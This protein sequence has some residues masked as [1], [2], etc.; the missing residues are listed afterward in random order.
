MDPMPVRGKK[1]ADLRPQ[2]AH[3]WSLFDFPIPSIS[4]VPYE[5]ITV[6]EI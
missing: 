3:Y 6:I 5:P 4:N 2:P 1:S